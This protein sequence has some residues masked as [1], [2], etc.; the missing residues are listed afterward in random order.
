MNNFFDSC[1]KI[2]QREYEID[3]DI[4]VKKKTIS[5][6]WTFVKNKFFWVK[7][8]YSYL[9]RTPMK[10]TYQWLTFQLNIKPSKGRHRS[11]LE[12]ISG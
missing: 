9:N 8:L 12:P 4:F 5:L 11:T 1:S 2:I 10:V 7:L 3:M 6:T